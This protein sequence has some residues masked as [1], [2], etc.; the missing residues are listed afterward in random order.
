MC[1]GQLFSS[2]IVCKKIQIQT[3]FK[4]RDHVSMRGKTSA[5]ME[6]DEAN[7]LVSPRSRD[8][9]PIHGLECAKSPKPQRSAEVSSNAVLLTAL[10]SCEVFVALASVSTLT[11]LHYVTVFFLPWFHLI[12]FTPRKSSTRRNLDV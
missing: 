10:F 12:L 6:D 3:Q 2:I 5:K 11:S 4:F 8:F 9:A 7:T 1:S